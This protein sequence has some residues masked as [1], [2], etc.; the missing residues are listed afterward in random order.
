MGAIQL[1][2]LDEIEQV[3]RRDNLQGKGPPMRLRD[4]KK[5]KE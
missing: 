1:M 5:G 3:E 2:S 4:T